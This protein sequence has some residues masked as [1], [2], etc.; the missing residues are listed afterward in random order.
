MQG[1]AYLV[2]IDPQCGARYPIDSTNVQC[3]K[4]SNVRLLDVRYANVP[5]ESLKETFYQRRNSHGNIFDESGV[6]RF[7][8][9]LNF[10]QMDTGRCRAVLR[11]PGLT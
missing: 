5:P 6:W 4:C 10:C 9:L 1:D 11:V 3:E 7:R 8:D 2:C